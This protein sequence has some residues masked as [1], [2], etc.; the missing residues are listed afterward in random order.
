MSAGVVVLVDADL[1]ARRIAHGRPGRAGPEAALAAFDAAIERLQTR[2]GAAEALLA[3]SDGPSFRRALWSGYKAARATR[4]RPKLLDP[5]RA[6]ARRR[7]GARS[8]EGLEADDLLGVWATAPDLTFAANEDASS[9]SGDASRILA[10]DDKDLDTVP[11]RRAALDGTR[12]GRISALA[13]D[14]AHLF[15]TLTGDASDGYRG[16]P[17]VGPKTAARLLAGPPQG[18][19]AAVRKA[20]ADARQ[21]P[22]EALLQARL[23][24]I[25]RHGE[26]DADGRPILWTPDRIGRGVGG[27]LRR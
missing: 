14:R 7:W 27:A 10:S 11:A 21:P 12:R 17:G 25:L 6:H 15:Q 3:L 19:W 24:R 13:G 2:L 5:L 9:P 4:A 18:W 26:V 8:R 20:F 1:V 22:G 16:C 23:A